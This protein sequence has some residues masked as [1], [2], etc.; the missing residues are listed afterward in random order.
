MT[1]R[2]KFLKAMRREWEGY[3]PKDISLCPS[4]RDRFEEQY[5]HGDY[6]SEWN[7]P[8]RTAGL[9]FKANS[10]DFSKW[11]GKSRTEQLWMR[12]ASGMNAQRMAPILSG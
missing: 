11:L 10:D 1:T 7:L 6:I 8:H 9:P 4:Q 12:G 2:E 5:G 3:V